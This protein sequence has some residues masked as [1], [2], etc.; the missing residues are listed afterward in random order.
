MLESEFT[1]KYGLDHFLHSK[2]GQ[3][4]LWRSASQTGQPH[5]TLPSIYDMKVPKLSDTFQKQV[6]ILYT[7]SVKAKNAE[8]DAYLKAEQILFSELKID[9]LASFAHAITVKLLSV[10]FI[11][12]GRLD[13][14]Y[15]QPKY[16]DYRYFM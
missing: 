2:Y 13:A 5:L 12:S 3:S 10:S 6:K 7:T 16:D 14:E 8:N 1:H 15:Y 11:S 9:D 4:L